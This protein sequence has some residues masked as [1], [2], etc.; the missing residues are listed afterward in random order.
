MIRG[1]SFSEK[2]QK[3]YAKITINKH[4]YRPLSFT[5]R[6][7]EACQQRYYLE[8]IW[9]REQL[10]DQYYM[11][12]FKKYRRGSEDILDLERTGQISEEEATYRHIMRY[13]ENAWYYFRY[14]L[15]EY[16]K[17]NNI[18]VPKYQLNEQGFM[19]D[20]I[21]QKRLCPY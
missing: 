3:Y 12:D 21:T 2:D 8:Q 20:R 14:G 5:Y 1:Y 4:S 7:D 17:D 6:E 10:G 16:Y 11:F 13:A 15:Q 18:P 9:L 19:V